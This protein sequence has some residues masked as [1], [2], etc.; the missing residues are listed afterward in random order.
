MI[1]GLG[2]RG[3]WGYKGKRRKKGRRGSCCSGRRR[4]ELLPSFGLVPDRNV[5]SCHGVIIGIGVKEG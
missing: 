4:L 5:W 2:R 3:R 1:E